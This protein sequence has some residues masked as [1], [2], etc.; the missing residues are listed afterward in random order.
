MFLRTVMLRGSFIRVQRSRVAIGCKFSCSAPPLPRKL[1]SPGS[2]ECLGIE[3]D[4]GEVLAPDD[5]AQRRARLVHVPVEFRLHVRDQTLVT[6]ADRQRRSHS[7]M[8]W[9]TPSRRSPTDRSNSLS[10]RCGLP[11]RA[12]ALKTPPEADAKLSSPEGR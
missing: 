11:G 6:L 7:P 12:R 1:R 3:A 2:H 9:S 10:C 5:L 8:E 4:P